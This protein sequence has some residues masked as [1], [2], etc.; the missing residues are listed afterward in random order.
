M[1]VTLCVL[2]WASAGHEAD[3]IAYEDQVLQWLPDHGGQVLQRARTT[4]APDEPLEVQ[5][6]GFPSEE[7]L[8]GF[9]RDERRM[10]LRH[11]RET[12]IARTQVLRV[13]LV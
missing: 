12:A 7:A 5:L 10:A 4:G 13:D 8:D 1:A 11:E 3:L 2:L 6:L 9:T